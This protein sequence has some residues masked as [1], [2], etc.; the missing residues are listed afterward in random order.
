MTNLKE[1]RNNELKWFLVANILIML[2]S[3]KIISGSNN[4]DFQYWYDNIG[5]II[6]IV[7]FSVTSFVFTFIMD[8]IVPSRLKVFLVFLWNKQPSCTIFT[9]L[10][11]KCRDNRF[12]IKDAK[13]KYKG[14]YL[15]I[16]KCSPMIKDQ[17]PLWYAIYNKHRNN[18]IVFGSNKDYLLLRDLHAQTIVLVIVYGMLMLVTGIIIF[19]LPYLIYLVVIIVLLNLAARI[20][21]RKM[22]YNVLAVDLNEVSNLKN[23]KID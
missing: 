12:T 10:E 20:Q 3:S 8:S 14:I 18:S 21:G 19:S 9:Q 15:E 2:I 7:I 1:Y 4:S 11:I 22:V 23:D 17:T 13:K 5:K 6:N 16:K